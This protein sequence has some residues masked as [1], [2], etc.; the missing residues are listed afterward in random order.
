MIPLNVQ[1]PEGIEGDVDNSTYLDIVE[2]FPTI[3]GEGPFSGERAVF[4]RTAGCNLKCPQ[5]DTDYTTNRQNTPYDEIWNSILSA[6]ETFNDPAPMKNI[7]V[8]LTGGEPMRQNIGHFLL[9]LFNQQTVEVEIHVQIESNGT[10]YRENI[11]WFAPN[12]T[13][14]VSPKGGKVNEKLIPYITAY[15][16]VLDSEF[17]CPEDGLPTE[18]LGNPVRVARPQGKSVTYIQPA[19][20]GDAEKNK[21]NLQACVKSCQTFGYRLSLQLHKIIG[22]A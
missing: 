2:I 11:P 4:V 7:F 19:D 17:V 22:V 18:Q 9:Y 14:V 5:C 16:Y 13:T 8:V 10:L 3:Q 21:L 12:L 20:S 1:E 6:Y 15:K